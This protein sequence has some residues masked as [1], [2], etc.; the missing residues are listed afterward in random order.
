MPDPV[1]SA[2]IVRLRY[3]TDDTSGISREKAGDDFRFIDAEGKRVT[4][5]KTLDR[6][7]SLA[8]PPAWTEVWICPYAN[9]HLQATGRD[10]RKRKQHRY[11]PKWREIRDQNKYAQMIAFAKALPQIRQRVDADLALSG[12]PRAKVLATVV[13]LLEVTLIRVGNEEY[14]K[15]NRSYGLT[16]LK[17]RHVDISGSKLHFHF[18]GKSGKN[19]EIDI[20]DRKLAKIVKGVQD[21]PG[22]E[23]F[24]Y[25]DDDGQRKQVDSDDVNTY[26]K[27]ITGEDFTA[28]CFRTWAGTILAAQALQEFKK[29]DSEVEAKKNVIQAI[30]SVSQRLGNTP[31][32]CRK[33][34]VHPAILELY[35]DA[36][37]V[38]TLTQQAGKVL[39]ESLQEL[40]PQ[41]AAVLAMLEKRLEREKGAA[42]H[43]NGSSR[44]KS[45]FR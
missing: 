40:S 35:M 28:K 23:L 26:L 38:E 5:E 30:K 1:E 37:L 7:N 19:H 2:K 15:E 44:W 14:A 16:T 4:D 8:I 45:S 39:S 17:D 32:I 34:Y 22:Q 31:T 42:N 41:E 25:I 11:H 29:C 13:K 6:I 18:K 36:A 33:C 20:H 12:F 21:L 43:S 27:E 9:G 10:A 24:Q 3:V